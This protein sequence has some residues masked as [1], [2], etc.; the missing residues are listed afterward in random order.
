VRHSFCV[1]HVKADDMMIP[2]ISP[3]R[4]QVVAPR[5]RLYPSLAVRACVLILTLAGCKGSATTPVEGT[6][7]LDGKPLA[8][9]SIQFVPQ[10]TGHDATGE[11][12]KNGQF[13]MSSFQPRDGV[14]A[15][16]YKVVISPPAGAAD[17]TPYASADEAMAAASKPPAKK[18]SE[19]PAFP[20]KYARPDQTPLNQEVPVKGKLKFDLKSS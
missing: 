19:G 5:P 9:A 7:L 17:P 18:A 1:P 2:E 8:G 15:G 3:Q 16:T 13:V 6:V 11:T 10:G 12:D 4:K 14:Q 20:Q